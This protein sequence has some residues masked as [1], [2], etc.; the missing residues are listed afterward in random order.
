MPSI[1]VR[2]G[3]SVLDFLYPW[4]RANA[5]RLSPRW[6]KQS[7][8][9]VQRPTHNIYCISGHRIFLGQCPSKLVCDVQ[10]SQSTVNASSAHART[11]S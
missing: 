7:N 11:L 4:A 8:G 10:V 1:F 6:R 5:F 3:L 2:A 9:Q